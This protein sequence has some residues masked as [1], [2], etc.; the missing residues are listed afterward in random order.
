[1]YIG[2]SD[3]QVKWYRKILEKD[4]DAVNGAGGKRESKT[5]LLNIVMQLRKCCNHPYLFEGAEPGPPYTTDEH[6]IQNAGKMLMMDRLLLRLKQQGSRVLIFSQMSRLLDILE[7]YCVFREYKYC[8]IDGSTAHEDRI[9]AIDDYNKPD[10]EKFIFLLT[11][12]AGGLGINLTSADIVVLYDSDWNPQADLQAMDRAHRI[13]QTKQVVVYRFVTENAIEEKVL[14]RAAQKLRLDQLVIQQGRAQIAAKAAANKDE[15]LNMI[16]HGAEK[17]FQT[18][19][20]TGAFAQKEGD[21]TDDD[22]DNILKHGEMRT[23]QLN[24]RY[25]KLGIDDLQKFTSESAYEWNGQDFTNKKKEIGINWINP[26]KRERKEQSYSMDKYYK[27]ALSTGG[28][29]ADTKPKAPRAPKQVTVHD[30]QFFPP[31]LRD[32]QDRETAYHRKEIGYKVPLPEGADEDLS[33]R[34]AERALD[35]AEIDNATPL[36]EEEQ[37]EKQ[38]LS[39]QGFA[40]WNRRDFQQFVNGS[41]KYGRKDYEAISDEVDS[42]TP[43]EIKAYAKVFW[44]RYTEIADYPKYISLIA[45]GE[46]K[47]RKIENQR[48]M[49]RK[50]MLQYRVPL[51]QLKINYSVSTT[52]KK[53]YTE[54]EDRFL[55]VLLDKYG[56]DSEGIFERIRD[57]IRESPLFRFD[58]FFLSRTPT[59]ISRRCT[60]LLTTVS[61]EFEDPSVSKSAANGKAKREVE[62]DENDEDSVL[63]MGPAKKKSKNG[64]KVRNTFCSDV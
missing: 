7:D 14:E 30:Y 16:Q 22:I 23:A 20:P 40:D 27:Q 31:T 29:V 55:L 46:E 59:E 47:T 63:G 57:D 3:M 64:V 28:R 33:D 2:M 62:E 42:K 32:L 26:A 24:A 43:E 39:Q 60:T 15:L 41:A 10:S 8:R 34:E 50:K 12:R 49:L 48:K 21:L 17:V 5:R 35:Q 44:V 13:G 25:E 18:K 52:N 36:T 19:G 58:W 61:R 45:A 51:Q 4:I 1:L 54:E 37:E 53:V 6:L 11:T 38:R 56:I 9:A